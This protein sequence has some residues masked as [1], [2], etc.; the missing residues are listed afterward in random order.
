VGEHRPE[1]TLPGGG[2]RRGGVVLEEA[3]DVAVVLDR[4]VAARLRDGGENEYE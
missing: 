1:R 4:T 3:D 2:E